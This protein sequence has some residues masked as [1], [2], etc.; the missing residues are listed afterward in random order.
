MKTRVAIIGTSGRKE[1][2]KKLSRSLFDVMCEATLAAIESFGLSPNDV[3]G[4]SGGAAW[5]DHVAVRLFLN[6]KLGGLLL[7]LPAS[8]VNAKFQENGFKSPGSIS[9]Y[10]H[11][12]FSQKLYRSN[13][14]TV[15]EISV[16]LSMV[17]AYSMVDTRGFKARNSSVA[18]DAD[19]MIAMTFSG[20]WDTPKDGGT[21]DTWQK[22]R[23]SP[24]RKIHIPLG[25]L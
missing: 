20:S 18:S 6:G 15:R 3:V 24:D 7:H 17:G 4:V 1:D 21:K 10:Y 16:A 11:R 25:E 2:G 22:C 12:L 9:N 8:I 13:W 14:D 23:T 19:H 5:A